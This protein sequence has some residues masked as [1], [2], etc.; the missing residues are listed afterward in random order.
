MKSWQTI[1]LRHIGVTSTLDALRC[2]SNN[3]YIQVLIIHSDLD[4]HMFWVRWIGWET[5]QHGDLPVMGASYNQHA[6]TFLL[7]ELI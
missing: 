5:L 3:R 2:D 1:Q 7:M 4:I 6:P